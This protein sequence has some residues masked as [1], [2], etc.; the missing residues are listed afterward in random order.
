VLDALRNIGTR[1]H[2]SMLTFK[3]PHAD[4]GLVVL[5]RECW[6]LEARL[7]LAY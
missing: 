1:R 7:D 5:P 2:V 4:G 6:M 3:P